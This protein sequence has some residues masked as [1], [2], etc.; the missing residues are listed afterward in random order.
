MATPMQPMIPKMIVALGESTDEVETGIEV[1]DGNINSD[2]EEIK[3]LSR[4]RF[5]IANKW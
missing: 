3:R 1:E 2:L 4:N 5:D